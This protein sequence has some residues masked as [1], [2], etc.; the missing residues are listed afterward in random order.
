MLIKTSE[1]DKNVASA[2]VGGTGLGLGAGALGLALLQGANGGGI[3][4]GL[5]GGGNAPAQ[6]TQDSRIISALESKIAELTSEKYTDHAISMQRDRLEALNEKVIG[7]VID[8]DKRVSSI[9]TAAP[10]R[11]QIVMDRIT[12]CCNASNA[13]ITALANTVAQVTRT[14]VPNTAVCPWEDPD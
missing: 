14:V 8:I 7:Y 3:L 13:A 12:C 6:A 5:L 9:E 11:E 4:N 10:L 1:G 2:G